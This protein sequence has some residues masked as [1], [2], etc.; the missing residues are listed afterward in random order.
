MYTK[1]FYLQTKV[2]HLCFECTVV[3]VQYLKS[4]HLFYI[5]ETVVRITNLWQELY[6]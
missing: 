1:I 4:V 2:Q 6:S 3:Y 5:S